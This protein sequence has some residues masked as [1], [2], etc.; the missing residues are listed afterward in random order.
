[1]ADSVTTDR[2]GGDGEHGW[3]SI[4]ADVLTDPRD[5]VLI[6][7]TDGAL[8][9]ASIPAHTAGPR[10]SE[11]PSLGAYLGFVHPDDIQRTVEVFRG[12]LSGSRDGSGPL[13]ARIR[14]AAGDWHHYDLTGNRLR[15]TG[16]EGDLL[17]RVR[18]VTEQ[19]AR[20]TGLESALA[21]WRRMHQTSGEVW[22]VTTADLTVQYASAS[23]ERHLGYPPAVVEGRDGTGYVHPDD[24]PRV[25]D[26]LGTALGTTRE[27]PPIELRVRAAD[28]RWVWVEGHATTA[29]DD[30]AVAGVVVILRAIEQHVRLREEVRSKERSLR[31][32]LD[33][34]HEGIWEVDADH[35]T[36]MVNRHIADLLGLHPDEMIG[37][38]VADLLG[39]EQAREIAGRVARRAP[40]QVDTYETQLVTATGETSWRLVHGVALFDDDGAFSGS[41]GSSVDIT[42][43]KRLERRLEQL[44]LYDP[45]TGLPNRALCEDRLQQALAA[46]PSTSVALLSIDVDRM[47]MLNDA[48]G[49][50]VGDEVLQVVAGR[51]AAGVSPGDTVARVDG[52][53]FAVLCP[54]RGEEQARRLAADLSATIGGPL[55]TSRGETIHVS[56]SVGIACTASSRAADLFVAADAALLSAKLAGRN[57]T[58][59]YSSEDTRRAAEDLR[60]MTELNET[61]SRDALALH[62]QPIIDLERGGCV[63][64]EALLRWPERPTAVSPADLVRVAERCHLVH[65]LTRWTLTRACR[66]AASWPEGPHGPLRVSVNLSP[67]QLAAP[68][69]PQV[70]LDALAETGLDPRRLL[71]EITETAVID[72]LLG[73]VVSPLRARGVRF[74][75]DDF[76][77]GYATLAHVKHLPLD[78]VKI[79]RSFIADLGHDEADATIVASL[80]SLAAGLGLELVAEGVETTEQAGRL[81]LLGCRLAQGFLWAPAV[82]SD[83][84]PAAIA[85]LRPRTAVRR[86]RALLLLPEVASR[87]ITLH[88]SG[89][90]DDSIAAALNA[91]GHVT[92]GG[93]RWRR[94]SVAQHLDRMLP[95]RGHR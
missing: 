39:E 66:D 13:R 55:R 81:G 75:L 90:S 93:T 44:T 32:V 61:M 57:R 91:E 73:T 23:L 2:R 53:A 71:L 37:R 1:M 11:L 50:S 33:S 77:T 69:L 67:R 38:P 43:Q 26:A 22:L 60:L 58:C 52:D 80:A 20:L 74:S 29:F 65:E 70:V 82:P 14:D 46:G 25:L 76:G 21:R 95:G 6:V 41:L 16:R 56:V 3:D 78:Q 54:G 86:G 31:R 4:V 49:R 79:D 64:V 92:P 9:Y 94:S 87:M 72:E 24:V 10:P 34:L 27:R 63:G 17:V 51:L 59:V 18:D 47:S 40:G 30:P 35:R 15:T 88:R 62:Y 8:R 12:W 85:R 42:R 28:G 84:L 68:G 36:V 5:A 48:V 89:A 83:R 45:L 7:N 19:Q